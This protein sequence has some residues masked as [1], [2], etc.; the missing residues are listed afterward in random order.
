MVKEISGSTS[1][2]RISHLES[3]KN[4]IDETVAPMPWEHRFVVAVHAIPVVGNLFKLIQKVI[5]WLWSCLA[6]DYGTISLSDKDIQSISP[7][8]IPRSIPL[9]QQL[10]TTPPK[11]IQKHCKI[12]EEEYE[13]LKK[14][15]SDTLL[16]GG[17][18]SIYL[19]YGMIPFNEPCMGILG[20]G[21]SKIAI[22]LKDDRVLMIPNMEVKAPGQYVEVWERMVEEEVAM[23]K[24]L[25]SIDLKSPKAQLVNIS[26]F[27]DSKMIPAYIC[28]TF[29]SLSKKGIYVV[30]HKDTENPEASTWR[31]KENFLFQNAQD[32]FNEKNWD[33]VFNSLCTDVALLCKYDI[34]HT[35][36]S[37]NIAIVEKKDLHETTSY[38]VRYFGF[39]F[40][41]VD[42]P[43]FIPKKSKYSTKG[44]E[45][46]GKKAEIFL[47]RIID[48][49]FL[50]ELG[51]AYSN[52]ESK[53]LFKTLIVRYTQEVISRIK[54]PNAN[55]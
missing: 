27:Q 30:D 46:Y 26:L 16:K 52:E 31:L 22:A 41:S 2:P 3:S 4:I 48:R 11:E 24:F 33:F 35:T 43:L 15:M 18:K 51:D 47:N 49:V 13:D 40:S 20:S 54:P 7:T 39:G 9:T 42:V 34:P 1:M 45:E 53:K 29:K 28:S 23:S 17:D 38:E 5:L 36:D 14:R 55:S 37:I 6:P 8:P 50:Y 44:Y 25:T 32:R 21:S 19:A 10:P 12:P